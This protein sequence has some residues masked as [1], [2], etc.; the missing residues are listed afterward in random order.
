MEKINFLV[1]CIQLIY[2]FFND[3]A[4]ICNREWT[5]GFMGTADGAAG[6]LVTIAD[7]LDLHKYIFCVICKTARQTD[8]G[9]IF[10]EINF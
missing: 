4:T 6:G 9:E 5:V 10:V 3:A 8:I 2:L 1:F 7:R